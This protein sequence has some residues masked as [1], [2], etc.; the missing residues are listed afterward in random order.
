ML[1][2]PTYFL[3]NSTVC[4]MDIA[5]SINFSSSIIP[6]AC[7]IPDTGYRMHYRIPD[8][9]LLFVLKHSMPNICLWHRV[10]YDVECFMENC[11]L[12]CKPLYDIKYIT[13]MIDICIRLA[14]YI[15]LHTYIHMHTCT[16]T[17]AHSY[18]SYMKFMLF[19]V[20]ILYTRTNIYTLTLINYN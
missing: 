18:I 4:G 11:T 12:D 13:Y 15:L 3:Q 14:R 7:S 16:R 8:G 17:H 10:L 2:N 20:L 5:F 6:D 19:I 1:N 9:F